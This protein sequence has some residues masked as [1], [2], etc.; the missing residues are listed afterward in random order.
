MPHEVGKQCEIIETVKK[1]FS[2]AM[3]ERVRI[4]YFLVQTIFLGEML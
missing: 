2:K 1:V 3:T 4:Y